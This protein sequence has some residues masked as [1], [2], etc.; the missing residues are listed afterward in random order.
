MSLDIPGYSHVIYYHQLHLCLSIAFFI[1]EDYMLFLLQAYILI[2]FEKLQLIRVFEKVS[3]T[4][5]AVLSAFHTE[6]NI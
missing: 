2:N 6:R 5:S 4:V 3:V 1:T